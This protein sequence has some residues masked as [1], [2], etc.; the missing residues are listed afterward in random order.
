MSQ[1]RAGQTA[2]VEEQAS[3]SAGRAAGYCWEKNPHEP[4]RYTWP[5]DHSQTY[6]DQDVYAGRQWHSPPDGGRQP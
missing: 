2:A 6:P 3:R 4:G 1:R 5:P